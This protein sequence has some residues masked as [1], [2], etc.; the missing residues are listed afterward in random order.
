MLLFARLTVLFILLALLSKPTGIY[1]IGFII[2]IASLDIIFIKENKKLSTV[3][4]LIGLV[5]LTLYYAAVKN[6]IEN[7]SYSTKYVQNLNILDIFQS[8]LRASIILKILLMAALSVLG[9]NM[10][11]YRTSTT[12]PSLIFPVGYI[13]YIMILS[14]WAL[15]NYLL[16]PVTPFIFGMFYPFYLKS[17]SAAARSKYRYWPDAAI[18]ILTFFVFT[19]IIVPRISKIAEIKKIVNEIVSLS[20]HYSGAKF[21]F[22]P[23]FDESRIA[24]SIYSQTPIEYLQDGNL[25]SEKLISQDNFL[26]FRDESSNIRLSDAALTGTVFENT[27]WRIFR[28]DPAPGHREETNVHFQ[29]TFLQKLTEKLRDR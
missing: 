28:I 20:E 3:Y 17:V 27:T 11:K 25:T 5:I 12:I 15:I 18:I 16:A 26:I 1:L 7:S 29:K 19:Q 2:A 23:P 13:V 6:V 14:P 8:I 24:V 22:P 21:F 4:L 9:I 10:L